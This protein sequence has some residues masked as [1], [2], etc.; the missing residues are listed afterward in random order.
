MKLTHAKMRLRK[1]SLISSTM[2]SK[3]GGAPERVVLVELPVEVEVSK[4][5]SKDKTFVHLFPFAK[6]AMDLIAGRNE[7]ERRGL[8]QVGRGHVP[9]MNV[10]IC[11]T[12][13]LDDVAP[14][15]VFT[16]NQVRVKGRPKLAID[17]KGDGILHMKIRGYFSLNDVAQLGPYI[18][19]DAWISTLPVQEVIAATT[20]PATGSKPSKKSTRTREAG[21]VDSKSLGEHDRIVDGVRIEV[22]PKAILLAE[23]AAATGKFNLEQLINSAR[24]S[25][26][27]SAEKGKNHVK[28]M[29]VDV[30]EVIAALNEGAEVQH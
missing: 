9:E 22:T 8:D 2:Q 20:A 4:E 30:E 26:L 27:L 12:P 16:I 23:Q 1:T 5:V 17:E 13:P 18:D 11:D 7:D 21:S 19:G 3:D 28:V 6:E 25:V 14:R 29:D 15:V 10:T 24:S